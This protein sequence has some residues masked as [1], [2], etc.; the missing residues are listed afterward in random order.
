MFIRVTPLFARCAAVLAAVLLPAAL[1]GGTPIEDASAAVHAGRFVDAETILLPL[2]KG[3][4]ANPAAWFYM[5]RVRLAQKQFDEAVSFADRAAKSDHPPVNYFLNLGEICF[6][7]IPNLDP[8]EGNSVAIKMR[9]AYE[10]ALK[11]DP[12]NIPAM[13]GLIAFYE[14]APDLVGGDKRKAFEYA[15]RLAKVSPYQGEFELGRLSAGKNDFEGAL[16]HYEAAVRVQP[17]DYATATACG[18]SLYKLNRK[19]EAR[20]RFEAVLR[21][22]P[23]FAP[24]QVGLDQIAKEEKEA[25]EKAAGKPSGGKPDSPASADASRHN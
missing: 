4:N 22:K 7:A 15:E 12:K 3:R 21:A 14:H 6:A 20:E 2:V 18:W 10:K 8:I 17:D 19:K 11:I 9:K 25:A 5:S 23:D 16:T 24:A 1:F 13:E